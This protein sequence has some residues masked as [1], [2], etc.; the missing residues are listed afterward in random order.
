MISWKNIFEKAAVLKLITE[1]D[2]FNIALGDYMIV[3]QNCSNIL[4]TGRGRAIR[5][6]QA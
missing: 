2:D 5:A 1:E 3:S 6:S 4:S